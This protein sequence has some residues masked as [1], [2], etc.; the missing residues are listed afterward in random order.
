MTKLG[1]KRQ[2]FDLINEKQT[3]FD[4]KMARAGF[5]LASP[6]LLVESSTTELEQSL[7]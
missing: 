2:I 3:N 5:E 1:F 6:E 7:I 4:E